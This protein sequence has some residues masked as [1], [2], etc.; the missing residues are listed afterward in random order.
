MENLWHGH[1]RNY[2]SNQGGW[3]N[4][5]TCLSQFACD[6][7]I[8]YIKPF[9]YVR[10]NYQ[11][12]KIEIEPQHK[13]CIVSNI[14]NHCTQFSGN[15]VADVV[16]HRLFYSIEIEICQCN[17]QSIN[18]FH[19]FPLWCIQFAVFECVFQNRY[20]FFNEKTYISNE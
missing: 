19:C 7:V 15:V 11:E 13:N 16:V 20:F 10:F 3:Y 6:T 4:F 18:F 12:K 9:A 17:G 1:H 14:S 8:Y 2:R 5:A